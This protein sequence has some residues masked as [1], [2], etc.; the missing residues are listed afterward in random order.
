MDTTKSNYQPKLVIHGAGDTLLGLDI[1]EKGFVIALAKVGANRWMPTL[2]IP[3]KLL[4]F[5][6][7]FMTT[8]YHLL[9]NRYGIEKVETRAGE[10]QGGN[11]D[12]SGDK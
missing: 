2:T 10:E 5:M 8:H 1:N 9:D 7:A 6:D 11:T 3:P 12:S 4:A